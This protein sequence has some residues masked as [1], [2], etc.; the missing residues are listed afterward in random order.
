MVM[1]LLG[2]ALLAF[3]P[4]IPS[5]AD[6]PKLPPDPNVPVKAGLPEKNFVEKLPG[7]TTF[8]MVFVPGGEFVMGSP[9]DEAGREAHE[10]PQLKV[11][12]RSF[13][14]AK[15]ECT[16]NEFDEWW[17]NEN[18]LKADE[19][20]S[21]QIRSDAITRPTAP[22]VD[23]LYEHG[24][25]GFPA[26]CMSHHAAMMYAHWL[27][28]RT[29]KGYRLPTEAEWEYACRAKGPGPYGVPEDKVGDFAWYKAN[30]PDDDHEKGTTH[31]CGT[32]QP[33][34]FGLHDMQ[35]NVWEWCLDHAEPDGF[36]KFPAGKLHESLFFKPTDRKYSHVVK[37]G[38]WADK[39][40]RLRV[41]ARR[42]SDK[43]WMKHDPQ[44]PQS[45]WWL[46]KMDV[47][48]FRVVL[49]VEEYPELVG[50]RPL[51]LKKPD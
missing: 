46:T 31:K 50:L 14:M 21:A 11:K 23:E 9:A 44:L 39:A 20:T 43:S 3:L 38:S 10:A 19:L 26:L 17:K 42:T 13:W 35:G 40:D 45:I 30:S 33:N 18:L 36:A 48:G 16:W 34:A 29:G 8:E 27:R 12:V 47:I 41:A 2:L 51:V 32:K 49:P 28:A 7:G 15:V 37:G 25:D 24:R 1:R 22:Y 4:A 6:E 5:R